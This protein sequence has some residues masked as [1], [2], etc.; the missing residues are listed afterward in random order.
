[1]LQKGSLIRFLWYGSH[2]SRG[3][4][5]LLLAIPAFLYLLYCHLR[6]LSYKKGLLIQQR[7]SCPVIS[8]GNLTV[9]GTGKTP[10]TLFIAEQWRKKGVRVGIV[11]RGYGGRSRLPI[12]PVS[13]GEQLL[14]TPASVGDEPVMMAERLFG[15][16]ETGTPVVVAKNRLLGCQWLIAQFKVGV[17]LLDDGFQHLQL[18][19]NLNLLL[20]DVTAPFGNGL[21]LPCGPLREPLSEIFRADVVIV[22]RCERGG[23]R[24]DWVKEIERRG[25]P[26]FQTT[27]RATAVT[28]IQTGAVSPVSVLTGQSVLAF[29]GV[30]NPDSFKKNLIALGVDLRGAIFFDDHFSYRLS[31]LEMIRERARTLGVDQIVT[32]EKDAVKIRS[33]LVQS[34]PS[35]LHFY[36]L[37]VEMEF[38]DEPGVSTQSFVSAILRFTP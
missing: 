25:I 2:W 4:A 1:M 30:G 38:L 5:R 36:A 35:H 33:L 3:V 10:M 20:I 14:A 29:C 15:A 9:G 34:G 18:H 27:L 28:E 37:R 22:T 11:S 21:L 32:T 19:R 17:I 12:V 16:G 13:D 8:I 23:A 26:C 6:V 31:D 24:P 7:V